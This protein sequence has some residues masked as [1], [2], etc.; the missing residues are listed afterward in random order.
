MFWGKWELAWGKER[1]FFLFPD[2]WNLWPNLGRTGEKTQIEPLDGVW[3]RAQK[4]GRKINCV[5][6]VGFCGDAGCVLICIKHFPGVFLAGCRIHHRWQRW[7]AREKRPW[8]VYKNPKSLGGSKQSQQLLIIE[9]NLRYLPWIIELTHA[10][11]L[12]WF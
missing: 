3:S 10:L 7:K 5:Y 8:T 4:H 9:K 12:M 11:F 2:W 6:V 1:S